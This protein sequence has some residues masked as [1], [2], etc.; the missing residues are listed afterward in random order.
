MTDALFP[1]PLSPEDQTLIELIKSRVR[2]GQSVTTMQEHWQVEA[3][4]YPPTSA[5]EIERAEAALGFLLPPLIRE[6]WRQIGNGG[7]GPGYGIT[8]VETGYPIYES[9]LI[10]NVDFLRQ[11]A[12]YLRDEAEE[13]ARHADQGEEQHQYA[14]DL[15]REA[16]AWYC[17]ERFILYA[18]WGCNVT[19]VVDCSSPD[20]PVHAVDGTVIQPHTSGTLRQWWLDW[21]EGRIQQY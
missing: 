4:L 6:I 7:F 2:D 8:G 13:A 18:Y 16:D 19:T 17:G 5:A 15:R 14:E 20:L 3:R 12:A 1:Q 11:T 21:L 10:E 9:T